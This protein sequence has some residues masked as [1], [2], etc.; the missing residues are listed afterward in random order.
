M[1]GTLLIV[2]LSFVV[3]MLLMKAVYFDPILKIK[4]ARERKI[5]EEQET[6]LKMAEEYAALSREYEAGLKKARQEA[7]RLIQEIRQQ[8]KQSAQDSLAKSREEALAE[9]A[10][11]MDA[12]A[13]WREETYRQMES[14]RESLKRTILDKVVIGSRMQTASAER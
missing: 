14:E 7:H 9:T 11:Q 13:Q 1:V 10:R 4:H 2:F 6:A 3:F 8:A 12:L 5:L